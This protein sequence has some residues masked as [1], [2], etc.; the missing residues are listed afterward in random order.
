MI[1]PG[2]DPALE[3]LFAYRRRQNDFRLAPDASAL[4]LVDL[5]YGSASPDHGF[6]A[7]YRDIGFGDVVDGYVSRLRDT[8]IPA[9]QRLQAAFR[10][11]GAPVVFLT[12]GTLTGDYGDLTPR[13]RRA[14]T[15]WREQG[16]E[17]PYA[18]LGT[19]EM[20]VLDEIAPLPGEPVVPKTGA[21]GFTA[22]P[23]ERVL[24][25]AG[26][27]QLVIGG[28]ATN[29]CVA[30]TLRDA[31]DRG[32][33]CV[34]VTDACADVTDAAHDIGIRSSAPFCRVETADAVI[35]EL[36]G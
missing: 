19:R 4:L 29:Y 16:L 23:L 27:R 25:G 12:V 7:I 13:F 18:R 31:A 35:A 30:S 22:S 6:N 3:R 15:Y 8:V 33:D 32:Y 17:P 10:A 5:Q 11:A 1:E 24:F 9:V 28:V 14:V 36:H 26:V 21:S 20:Q 2:G 34:L